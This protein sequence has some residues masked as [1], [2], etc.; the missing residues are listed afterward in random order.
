MRDLRARAADLVV[1]APVLA[2]LM[3]LA[4]DL[5]RLRDAWAI[6]ARARA[7]ASAYGADLFP[8]ALAIGTIATLVTVAIALRGLFHRE[9][10]PAEA[11]RAAAVA[12]D[13]D[14]P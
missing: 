4:V 10:D 11:A 5:L 8:P 7:W 9:R 14:R 12:A 6:L 3:L 2:S 1:L 13:P